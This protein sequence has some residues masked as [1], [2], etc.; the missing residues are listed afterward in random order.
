MAYARKDLSDTFIKHH[1]VCPLLHCG[2]SFDNLDSYLHH[3]SICPRLSNGWYR[4]PVCRRREKFT[5][6]TS[7]DGETLQRSVQKKE[8]K[9]RRAITFFKSF[10]CKSLSRQHDI[11]SSIPCKNNR[12]YGWHLNECINEC[13]RDKYELP[14][15]PCE[16]W[17]HEL[18]TT[19]DSSD[20]MKHRD[21]NY[22]ELKVPRIESS[23]QMDFTT[24]KSNSDPTYSGNIKTPAE[25][26]G[27]DPPCY[28]LLSSDLQRS[29]LP[30]DGPD[31]TQSDYLMNLDGL[32][33][34]DF[35]SPI[36]P[37]LTIRE[38]TFTPLSD[39]VSPISP[40]E[41]STFPDLLGPISP[42]EGGS[43]SDLLSPVSPIENPPREWSMESQ[44]RRPVLSIVT[45][46]E[47]LKMK[48][49][50]KTTAQDNADSEQ[51]EKLLPH[52]PVQPQ[53]LESADGYS[54]GLL[55]KDELPT[56]QTLVKDVRD[57]VCS[58]NNYW[59]DKL[60]SI[61]GLQAIKA[62]FQLNS[63]VDIGFQA[64]QR[65]F[66]GILPTT[67]VGVFS[68]TEL[69]FA[70]AYLI[71]EDDDTYSWDGFFRDVLE[72]RHASIDEEDQRLFSKVA[73]LIWSP[74]QMPEVVRQGVAHPRRPLLSSLSASIE[75]QFDSRNIACLSEA[76][77]DLFTLQQLPAGVGLNPMNTL[78]NDKVIRVCSR[79]LDGTA[80]FKS[81]IFA[82][83]IGNS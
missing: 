72:W 17:L 44:I 73:F 39:L 48:D 1:A 9:L 6:P 24:C 67:F 29:E 15:R 74:P 40:I 56:S 66:R 33:A 57:L 12:S 23:N 60:S 69:A 18:D 68:L 82:E 52:N 76:N 19:D 61:S 7:R 41:N 4:C 2:K 32:E 64:L 78:M 13:I 58:L 47:S 8:T 22:K 42:I 77:S 49:L 79:F 28:E 31:Q 50:S 55:S 81:L 5:P 80:P 71:Y 25:L 21:A 43:L 83:L 35:I 59:L 10:G 51:A 30:A 54:N 53:A 65:C 36:S 70:C 34:F 27:S 38:S 46:Y 45:N 75:S 3:V 62:K 37:T 20:C 14:A 16:S 63:P 11:C 26:W